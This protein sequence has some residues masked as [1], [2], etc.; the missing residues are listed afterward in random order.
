MNL[1]KAIQI[2][3]YFLKKYNFKLNY[4]KLIK[5]LYIT[6]KEALRRWDTP[7]SYDNY[8]SMPNGPVLSGIYDLVMGRHKNEIE[9]LRWDEVFQRDGY[10]LVSIREG[11]IRTDELSER[12]TDLSDEID[13]KF[14][15]W[16][17]SKLIRLTHNKK[18]FPEWEDPGDSSF[19]L[20]LHDVLKSVG[21]EEEEIKEILEEE[22]I[23]ESEAEYF[24]SCCT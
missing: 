8:S 7:V 21:R 10:D 16:T 20:S 24:S 15:D 19:P 14:H 9:Q 1:N 6:D 12:E 4:T 2:V 11:E 17:Y 18:F 3:G 5:L 13:A 22:R 23:F